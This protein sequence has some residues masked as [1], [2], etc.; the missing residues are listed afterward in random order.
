M[1][2]CGAVVAALIVAVAAVGAS[3]N[4]GEGVQRGSPTASA[5]SPI[6][7]ASLPVS[8]SNVLAIPSVAVILA[9]TPQPERESVTRARVLIQQFGLDSGLWSRYFSASAASLEE[10]LFALRHELD[11]LR[12]TD[13]AVHERADH[14]IASG[15]PDATASIA[16][17]LTSLIERR[18]KLAASMM[19][20]ALAKHEHAAD[21]LRR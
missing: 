16:A 15:R 13:D 1:T 19:V 3:H 5:T 10:E 12:E 18:R 20:A 8:N 2:R 7:V 14:L 17:E 11:I 6:V 9:H 21:A 4:C